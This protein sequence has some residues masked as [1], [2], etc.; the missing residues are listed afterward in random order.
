M[1]HAEAELAEAGRGREAEATDR[2]DAAHARAL[3]SKMFG[4]S[5]QHRSDAVPLGQATCF[6]ALQA[7]PRSGSAPVAGFGDGMV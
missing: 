7:H 1:T 6:R 4:A 2:L 3:A 5:A